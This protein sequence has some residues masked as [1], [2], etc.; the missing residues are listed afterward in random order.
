[1]IV[2]ITICRKSFRFVLF[3]WKLSLT[4]D[5]WKNYCDSYR[6]ENILSTYCYRE[7]SYRNTSIS[8]P[9]V[10][11]LEL[12]P[13]TV[14]S[15]AAWRILENPRVINNSAEAVAHA[16]YIRWIFFVKTNYGFIVFVKVKR[17]LHA[18]LNGILKE[19]FLW[20]NVPFLL[21]TTGRACSW[22]IRK[23]G[24]VYRQWMSFGRALVS[25]PDLSFLSYTSP[26]NRPI[27]SEYSVMRKYTWESSIT[28]LGTL[29]LSFKSLSLVVFELYM[30]EKSTNQKRVFGHALIHL[31]K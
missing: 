21:H 18:E 1:M 3:I 6:L 12:T 28:W 23:P 15:I 13:F 22:D 31:R 25:N 19:H 14:S 16:H 26:K 11:P 29:V 30:S 24:P 27:R 17:I 2:D 5:S 4:I 9:I 10:T 7:Q 20:V 8:R